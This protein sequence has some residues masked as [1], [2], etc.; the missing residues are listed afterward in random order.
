MKIRNIAIIAHVDHGKTTLV[1]NMLKQS[2]TF[3]ENEKV[4]DRIMDSGDIERERGITIS[5]KPTSVQWGEYKINIVDTPGHADFG[6]EVERILSM[7]DGV[8]LLVDSAEGPLPQTKFVLSKALKLG[9][10]PIVCINKIDRSDARPDEVLTETFDLFDK[11][12]ATDSQLDFP[13]LYSCGRDGWA[14]RDLNDINNEH[15]DLTPLFQLIVDHV[16]APDCNGDRCQID[17]PFKMLATTLEADPYVGR[18]LTGKIESGTVKV[19]QSVKAI[20]MNGEFIE[21]AKITKII[22]HQGVQKISRDSASA[23]D[24]VVVAGFS[25]ATVADTLCDPSVNE[26][27]PA[28]PIDPPTLTMTFFVNTSP[29]AGKS[30]KKLTSRMI[31]ERLFKEAETNIAL[32]VTQSENNE[33]FEVSGRGELQLGILIET[34]RREGFELSV[35]RP[36]VV[37]QTGANG[38]KLEPIEEVVIDVDDEFSG[39]VIEK[40]TKRKA[41]ITEM[42]ASGVGKTRIVFSAPS[43]GLIGYLSEFR[44]DTRGTGIMNRVF[45]KYDEYRGPI[46]WYRPGVLVSMEAGQ[47]ATYALHNLEPRGTLFVGPQ[48]EVYSGMIIGEHS[49]ENDIEV[50][51][52]RG[53]QLTNVRSVTADEKLFLAPPRKI[54]LEEALSYIQD[55][56]LVEVTPATIRLRKKELDSGKRKKAYRFAESYD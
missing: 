13:Y 31:G 27:I 30:G 44:T 29:L 7:V 24:I 6:G 50:N 5:A 28:M 19:G 33:A 55:D 17:A 43:R 34:M 4:E 46:D 18:I 26:P 23:G 21:N 3:R 11:L 39:T 20:N 32:R 25:K 51:P 54:S 40:M 10:R 45:D 56:E 52:V 38:E 47:T 14:I 9:L 8:V 16:P 53:K 42:K 12:G 2:G 41:M 48:T 1:D 15:K 22:E 35:S 37:M 36:R 49:K